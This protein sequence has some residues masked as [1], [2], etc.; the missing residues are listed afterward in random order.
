METFN[1]RQREMRR[2]D[3]QREK[4]AR[5]IKRKQN[6]EGLAG[7]TSSDET[8]KAGPDSLPQSNQPLTSKS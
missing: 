5:R 8:A 4:A 7:D 6:R 1:K 3:R 2:V